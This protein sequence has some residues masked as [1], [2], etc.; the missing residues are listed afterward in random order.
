MAG[1]WAEGSVALTASQT[2]QFVVRAHRQKTGNFSFTHR[3]SPPSKTSARCCCRRYQVTTL[4]ALPNCKDGSRIEET[5]Q[6]YVC[7]SLF[8]FSVFSLILFEVP[9]LTSSTAKAVEVPAVKKTE[10][11]VKR[12][13]WSLGSLTFHLELGLEQV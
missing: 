7:S 5:H 4:I 1:W 8:S 3:R 13:G 12:K 9:R 11:V 6:G 2:G 10:K